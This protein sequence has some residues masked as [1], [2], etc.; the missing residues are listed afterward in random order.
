MQRTTC[1]C[2]RAIQSPSAVLTSGAGRGPFHT[3]DK[4][5]AT[6]QVPLPLLPLLHPSW[7]GTGG[8]L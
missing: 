5:E 8:Q 2:F 1:P 3:Q 6:N 7:G 4:P